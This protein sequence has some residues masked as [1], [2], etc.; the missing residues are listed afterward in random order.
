[1]I[2]ALSRVSVI[3]TGAP[4]VSI[5]KNL[6]FG[7]IPTYTIEEMRV[8]L[9]ESSDPVSVQDKSDEDSQNQ[10]GID[11]QISP[12]EEDDKNDEDYIPENE[13]QETDEDDMNIQP[14]T[15][16][17]YEGDEFNIFTNIDDGDDWTQDFQIHT[18]E[19]K[20]DASYKL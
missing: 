19:R 1:M 11:N 6:N 17:D 9:S 10:T 12:N 20:I 4:W 15:D 5:E 3:C 14:T 16:S 13:D 18:E 7:L 8:K 2:L